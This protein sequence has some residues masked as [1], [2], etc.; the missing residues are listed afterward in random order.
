MRYCDFICIKEM[1]S[2]RVTGKLEYLGEISKYVLSVAQK[3]ELSKKDT[4]RLRLAVDEI[5]TNIIVHGYEEAGIEGEII[6]KSK[7][8]EHTVTI[9]L[10]DT[11]TQ[12]DSTQKE[13]PDNLNNPLEEREIGGLGIY[14]AINGVDM[15]KYERI[16]DCNRNIFV[17]DRKIIDKD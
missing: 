9:Y 3:A 10:E 15:F 13:E 8:E 5:A 12:Y 4:Y 11:G 2:L 6:C 7:I 17:I 16:G 1:E 14:L